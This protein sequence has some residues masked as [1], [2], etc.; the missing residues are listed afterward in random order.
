MSNELVLSRRHSAE[1]AIVTLNRPDKRNALNVA[2]LSQLSVVLDSLEKDAACRVVIFG[3]EGNVFC[4]GM[5]LVE[6]AGAEAN[7]SAASGIRRVLE[8]LRDSR[9]VS[10][11]AAHGAAY[12][13]GGGLIAACDL[14][15]AADDLRIAFPETRRGLIPALVSVVLARKLRDGDLRE[16]FLVGEPVSP[17]RAQEI[18]LVQRVVPKDQLLAHTLAIAE[19]VTLGGPEAV[20]L[21]KQLLNR[22]A[23]DFESLHTIHEQVRQSTEAAEGLAAFRESRQPNWVPST[24]KKK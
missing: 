22:R 14:V 11:A 19:R 2:M 12:G 15:V 16:L 6:A 3:G 10:I 24:G 20:R 9:L 21:T 8:Q 5:D 7:K 17:L 23:T 13:G 4:A 18:G 1:I